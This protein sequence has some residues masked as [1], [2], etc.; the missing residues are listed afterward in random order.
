MERAYNCPN[1]ASRI[2]FKNAVVFNRLGHYG[3]IIP[4]LRMIK[5]TVV[6]IAV[7]FLPM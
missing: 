4:P 5:T 3:L 6:I 1:R 7:I 2:F